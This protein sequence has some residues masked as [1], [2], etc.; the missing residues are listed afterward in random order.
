MSN[1]VC[2]GGANSRGPRLY[3]LDDIPTPYR[4]GVQRRIAQGWKSAFRIAYCAEAEPGRDWS[5]DFDGLDVEFLPGRQWRPPLQRN[6]FSFKWNPTVLESLEAFQPDVVVLSG[7]AHSTMRRAARWCRRNGI[8]YGMAC[9]TSC[10]SSHCDG[11][12]WALKRYLVGPLVR[13]MA[14]GLPVGRESAEYLRK[15]GAHKVPMLFFPN[16]PDTTAI[17]SDADMI[18]EDAS[19][20]KALRLRLGIPPNKKILLFVGRLI[21]AKRPLDAIDAFLKLDPQLRSE[22]TLVIVGDGELRGAVEA[23]V[24]EGSRIVC[25]GWLSDT[26]LLAK[27]MGISACMLLPS[28]HEPWGAVVN[29]AMAAGIPVIASDKVCSAIELI[30]DGVHGF[31]HPVGDIDKITK[32]LR[33]ILEDEQ[34]QLRM[35]H[36][37]RHQ[38]EAHGE[39]FAASNLLKAV[40]GAL[41]NQAEIIA[42]DSN[43]RRR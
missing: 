43:G 32:A 33:S 24:S 2:S 35:G 3:Y 41:R 11:W 22:A 39:K 26:K 15:L 28:A 10:R 20:E 36:A 14:F 31:I 27:L 30:T 5:L 16:T 40:S 1:P 13:D 8:P 19:A 37:A 21:D 38:A 18:R 29:E 6:P 12:R 42:A 34:Q 25:L 23:K 9:E 17:I 7:Y 4:L